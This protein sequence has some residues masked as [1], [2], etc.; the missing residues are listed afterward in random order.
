MIKKLKKYF[1]ERTPDQI[2]CSVHFC[3]YTGGYKF[4][5]WLYHMNKGFVFG[6]GT[7]AL[8]ILVGAIVEGSLGAALVVV[9]LLSIYSF[10]LKR[11]YNKL[12]KGDAS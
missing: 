6:A 4:I 12:K 8:L 5:P 2:E 7:V 9:G 1:E 11:S 10:L 3:D